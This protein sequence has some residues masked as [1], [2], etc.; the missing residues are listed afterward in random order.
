[1]HCIQSCPS[2]DSAAENK[3]NISNSLSNSSSKPAKPNIKC[4]AVVPGRSVSVEDVA[5]PLRSRNNEKM[6]GFSQSESDE[7]SSSETESESSLHEDF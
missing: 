3:H 1:M 6:A 2:V 4:M 7:T 5:G